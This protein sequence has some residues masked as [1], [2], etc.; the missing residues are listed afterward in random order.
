MVDSIIGKESVHQCG[1]FLQIDCIGKFLD[2]C[3]V[4]GL[5]EKDLFVTVDLHEQ[6]DKNMVC[7]TLLG[8][9]RA[10]GRRKTEAIYIA[11][12]NPVIA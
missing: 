9:G 3:R 1:D 11:F 2:G 12:A 7:E 8:E 10:V 4:Y 6:T 5:T